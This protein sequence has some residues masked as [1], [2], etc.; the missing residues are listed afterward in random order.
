MLK[1]NNNN[2]NYTI[3]NIIFLKKMTKI[4]HKYYIFNYVVFK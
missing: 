4:Q 3:K 1:L 2:T